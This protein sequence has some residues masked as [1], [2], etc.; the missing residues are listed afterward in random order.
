MRRW[1]RP[2]ALIAIGLLT[3][4]LFRTGRLWVHYSDGDD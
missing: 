2:L 4:V 1:I 3:V